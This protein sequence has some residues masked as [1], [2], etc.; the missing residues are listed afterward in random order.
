MNFCLICNTESKCIEVNKDLAPTVKMF[1]E[2]DSIE[3]LGESIAT[4]QKFQEYQANIYFEKKGLSQDDFLKEYNSVKELAKK[5]EMY[6][7][8]IMKENSIQEQLKIAYR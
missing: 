5:K 3:R 7:K 1:F 8:A 2:M 4:I 6:K